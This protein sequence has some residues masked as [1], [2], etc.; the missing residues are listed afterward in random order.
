MSARRKY[1]DAVYEAAIARY[2]K[3]ERLKSI[4]NC[5][6]VPYWTVVDW[7]RSLMKKGKNERKRLSQSDVGQS[8]L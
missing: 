8:D 6:E 7:C 2:Q 3:R 4:A 1:P 5:L